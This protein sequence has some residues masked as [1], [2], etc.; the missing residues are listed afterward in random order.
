MDALLDPV[1]DALGGG[2][3]TV[4][5]I[6]GGVVLLWLATKMVKFAV[7][8]TVFAIGGALLLSAAPWASEGIDTPAGDCAR[9]AVE[10]AMNTVEDLVAK[11]VTVD[12]A[13]ADAACNADGDGLRAGTAKARL[14][15]VYDI[16]FQE[17]TVDAEGATPRLDIPDRP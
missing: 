1:K 8:M 14:R 10:A 9:Q 3:L 12:D 6:G 11:R 17:F 7:K 2:T 15:T 5:L 13:S 16:P 4:W